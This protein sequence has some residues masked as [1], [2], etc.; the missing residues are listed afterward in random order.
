MK[1][2]QWCEQSGEKIVPTGCSVGRS[3]LLHMCLTSHVRLNT[4]AAL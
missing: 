2:T 1:G 3:C 4:L